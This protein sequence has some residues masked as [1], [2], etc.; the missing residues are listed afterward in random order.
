M[1]RSKGKRALI[2]NDHPSIREDVSSV[3]L[4]SCI[5]ARSELVGTLEDAVVHLAAGDNFDLVITDLGIAAAGSDA[6][7]TLRSHRP[8][9]PLLVFSAN[10]G[11][12]AIAKAFAAGA[13]GYVAK[14]ANMETL[15][16]AVGSVMG[17]G[18]T[19]RP[20]W[21]MLTPSVLRCIN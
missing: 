5:I 3:L 20:S 11:V 1:I 14:S 10:E 13:R 19:Y 18:C 16:H 7:A 17:G 9:V 4:A 2:V 6:V 21:S 15:I 8:A 12:E